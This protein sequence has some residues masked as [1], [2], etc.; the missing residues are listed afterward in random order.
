MTPWRR[1]RRGRDVDIPRRRPLPRRRGSPVG[2]ARAP[3]VPR[4]AE[5]VPLRVVGARRVRRGRVIRRVRRRRQGVRRRR[6]VMASR[7]RRVRRRTF[8]DS[9]G[10]LGRGRRA[11]PSLRAGRR[12]LPARDRFGGTSPASTSARGRVG[13]DATTAELAQRLGGRG[14]RRRRDDAGRVR[15]YVPATEWKTPP[16]G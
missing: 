16:R 6:G 2:P 4:L 14:A 11:P 15:L 9:P 12:D 1:V 5:S 10:V 3:Q 13:A 7:G 8:T